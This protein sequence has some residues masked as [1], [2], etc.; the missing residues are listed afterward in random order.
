MPIDSWHIISIPSASNVDQ[1]VYAVDA[2]YVY[3][4]PKFGKWINPFPEE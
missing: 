2:A 3:V 4:H 1:V